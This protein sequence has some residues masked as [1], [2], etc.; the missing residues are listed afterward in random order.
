MQNTLSDL[1]W[2]NLDW[3]DITTVRISDCRNKAF[4]QNLQVTIQLSSRRKK[5][6]TTVTKCILTQ[7]II[8]ALIQFMILSWGYKSLFHKFLNFIW[9]LHHVL[10]FTHIFFCPLW[11]QKEYAKKKSNTC[12][13]THIYLASKKHNFSK[14]KDASGILP[15][16][17]CQAQKFPKLQCSH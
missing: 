12:T 3:N 9:N 14:E 8:H 15:M 4:L 13:H 16:A 11:F 17:K 1:R 6:R 5:K 2:M 7:S 10:A